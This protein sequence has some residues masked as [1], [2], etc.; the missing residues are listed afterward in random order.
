M[1]ILRSEVVIIVWL[2]L[3]SVFTLAVGKTAFAKLHFKN[4]L[5]LPQKTIHTMHRIIFLLCFISS[6]ITFA[7]QKSRFARQDKIWV[8]AG[9]GLAENIGLTV[10]TALN[11]Q[12]NHFIFTG[13]YL[14][15]DEF[16]GN[17][18][19]AENS[20]EVAL[21]AGW[22]NRYK[23]FTIALQAG[24]SLQS[25]MKRGKFINSF[26]GSSTYEYYESDPYKNTIGLTTQL[27]GFINIKYVG[28]GGKI[29]SSINKERT[30]WGIGISIFAGKLRQKY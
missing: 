13:Q 6:T 30:F 2:N 4:H 10:N 8:D 25:G 14:K 17:L 3:Y 19:P 1:I 15:T 7:Q 22:A 11:Y 12:R 24:P 9:L 21:L 5:Y 26:E 16:S 20:E 27:Q 18:T 23:Y 29:F 28:L